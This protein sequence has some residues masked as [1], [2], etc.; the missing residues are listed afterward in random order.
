MQEYS[1]FEMAYF[2][3][4]WFHP[5]HIDDHMPT[6]DGSCG[7]RTHDPEDWPLLPAPLVRT[8]QEYLMGGSIIP[9]DY[10]VLM[11]SRC[12]VNIAMIHKYIT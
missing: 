10:Y 3:S 8:M 12:T 1:F 11:N 2:R 9:C 6:P 5:G 4:Y 7:I